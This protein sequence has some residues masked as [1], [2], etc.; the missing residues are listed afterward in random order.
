MNTQPTDLQWTAFQYISGD[1]NPDEAAGFESLLETN[2]AAREAVAEAVELGH[3]TSKALL[4]TMKK[5]PLQ[6]ASGSHKGWSQVAWMS[7]GAA[8][9]LLF[10]LLIQPVQLFNLLADRGV[11]Q[12]IRSTTESPELALAWAQT[13][14]TVTADDSAEVSDGNAARDSEQLPEDEI[15]TPSWMLAAVVGLTGSMED[16]E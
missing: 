3:I 7:C 4:Q 8:L 6:L 9:C 1:L 14:D 16:I 12:A 2:Q 10:V 15:A 5:E 13:R 11:N